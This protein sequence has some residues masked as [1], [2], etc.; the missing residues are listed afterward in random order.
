MEDDESGGLTVISGPMFSGKSDELIRRLR[1]H[2]IA[3]EEIVLFKPDK[4]NRYSEGEVVTHDGAK[5][6]A[7]VIPSDRSCID[8]I[9]DKSRTAKVIGFDE[10]QFWGREVGLPG[11]IKELSENKSVYVTM[12]NFDFMGRPFESTDGLLGYATNIVL[13]TAVC[14][15]CNSKNARYSQRLDENGNPVLTGETIKVG[16]NG[17][18]SVR[19]RKDFLDLDRALLSG[20]N[21]ASAGLNH[22]FVLLPHGNRT[23]KVLSSY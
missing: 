18:Y 3:H 17:L 14:E 7:M 12:L 13:R 20:G 21:G 2:I 10:A 22:N 6:P 5:L 11:I 1:R 9:F 8:I 15:V 4:D 23:E 19:C 16:G